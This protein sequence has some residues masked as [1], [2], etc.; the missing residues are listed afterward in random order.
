MA[1]AWAWASASSPVAWISAR[2]QPHLQVGRAP[3]E[4]RSAVAVFNFTEATMA[5]VV[6][7]RNTAAEA[8]R[9]RAQG[10]DGPRGKAGSV[11]RKRETDKRNAD[12]AVTKAER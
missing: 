11:C 9:Q 2:L 6:A 7:A 4:W 10:C 5:V 3:G 8:E 12:A 1:W